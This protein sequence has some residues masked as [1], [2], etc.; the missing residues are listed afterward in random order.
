ML[1]GNISNYVSYEKISKT[2]I[3]K[4]NH[5]NV[6]MLNLPEGEE[7]KPHISTVDA[8]VVVQNGEV[9]FTLE[10]EVFHLK[11]GDVFC[12]KAKQVHSLKAKSNF[13]M[14]IVK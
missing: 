12:F 13:S 5:I 14:L 11:P 9:E 3:Y 1:I 6:M 8:F 7:L 10:G 2:D 4:D